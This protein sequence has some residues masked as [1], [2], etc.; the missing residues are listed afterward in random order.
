MEE[1]VP[2]E[3]KLGRRCLGLM[4]RDQKVMEKTDRSGVPV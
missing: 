1:A 3:R 2:A 4:D